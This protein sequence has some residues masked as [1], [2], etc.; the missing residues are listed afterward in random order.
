MVLAAHDIERDEATLAECCRASWSGTRA[1]ELAD[2]AITFGFN[3][4][5]A[6]DATIEQVKEWL[7]Q[8]QLP[9]LFVNL[10][11]I[12]AA[13]T[14]HAMV[15]VDVARGRVRALDPLYGPRHIPRT[16]LEQGWRLM[17]HTAI[18]IGK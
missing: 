12:D 18:I 2:C 3:A 5:V 11:P 1:S 10:L 4:F 6:E 14:T 17:K 8:D 15:V 16:L 9:I 13:A 7:A